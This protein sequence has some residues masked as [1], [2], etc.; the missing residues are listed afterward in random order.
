MGNWKLPT[1][2]GKRGRIHLRNDAI[3]NKELSSVQLRK[4]ETG[5]QIKPEATEGRSQQRSEQTAKQQ[6]KS[7]KPK[8]GALER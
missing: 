2:E 4:P 3:T 5:E 1:D 8:A 6:R 7:T